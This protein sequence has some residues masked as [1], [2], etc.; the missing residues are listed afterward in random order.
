MLIEALESRQYLAIPI[1]HTDPGAAAKLYL[2]FEG[3]PAQT[4]DGYNVPV[5]PAYSGMDIEKIVAIVGEKF[6]PFNLDVTT[7]NPHDFAD[8]HGQEIV[9]GGRDVWYGGGTSS[10]VSYIGSFYRSLYS[11]KSWVFSESLGNNPEY[12]GDIIAHE[13]GHAFGLYH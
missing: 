12:V 6:S 11:N 13:A 1:I 4:W 3:A 5:T 8:K 9:I 10:G 2:N 7:E